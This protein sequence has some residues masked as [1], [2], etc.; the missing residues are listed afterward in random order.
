[1]SSLQA[2]DIVQASQAV[3]E[4]IKNE[5]QLTVFGQD[6]I[7]EQ[8]KGG[9]NT[10]T[11]E[12][13]KKQIRYF[14]PDRPFL[15]QPVDVDLMLYTLERKSKKK[16]QLIEMCVYIP[17]IVVVILYLTF[18]TLIDDAYYMVCWQQFFFVTSLELGI[19]RLVFG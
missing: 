2:E 9:S 3:P 7:G 1:M 5:V 10:L 12:D 14:D 17:F 15:R 18:S 19:K 13:D 6:K 16:Q 4:Q 11:I 8:E